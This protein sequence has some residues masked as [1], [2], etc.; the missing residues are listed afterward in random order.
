LV[1]QPASDPKKKSSVRPTWLVIHPLGP[2]HPSFTLLYHQQEINDQ[3]QS[4]K[5]KKRAIYI[6]RSPAN[7]FVNK[8]LR[9]SKWRTTAAAAAGGASEPMAV[10][11]PFVRACR[12]MY[13]R[14]CGDYYLLVLGDARNAY[15]QYLAENTRDG[16][17]HRT[18]THRNLT[19]QD[20]EN[21]ITDDDE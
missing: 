2:C 21:Q 15:H 7:Q 19:P 16:S 20:I 9:G 6:Y 10:N 12:H 11:L 14:T 8:F 13:V 17:Q 5:Q 18:Q 4:I 1:L 3:G